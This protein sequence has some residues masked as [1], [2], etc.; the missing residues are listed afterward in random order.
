M[1]PVLSLAFLVLLA[2]ASMPVAP[3]VP[4]PRRPA[5]VVHPRHVQ[6]GHQPFES[7]T[8]RSFRITNTSSETLLVTIE[9]V[10]V[11]DDV[12]PGQVESTCALGD[13]LLSPHQNCTQVVGFRPTE[14][15]GG[16]ETALMRVIAH[17]DSGAVRYDELVMLSGTGF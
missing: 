8:L 17:D 11:G 5:L 10:Q 3:A 9:Q 15:F 2:S 6:F 14:F 4:V 1:K 13:T 16:F 12:S 7:N